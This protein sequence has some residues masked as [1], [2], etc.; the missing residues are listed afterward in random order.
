MGLKPNETNPPVT[1]GDARQS[2]HQVGGSRSIVDQQQLPIV[3]NLRKHRI[4][5]LA[6]PWNWSIEHGRHYADERLRNESASFN[7]HVLQLL[8]TRA[9]M[10]KPLLIFA[11]SNRVPRCPLLLVKLSPNCLHRFFQN[12]IWRE[13]Y[14]ANPAFGGFTQRASLL[15]QGLQ[16]TPV[17]F[18]LEQFF[19]QRR[20]VSVRFRQF[21]VADFKLSL[22]SLQFL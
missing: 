1:R 3:I 13:E 18:Q 14:L 11:L 12:P 16:L 2:A 6:E 5:S 21:A 4:H 7:A 9:M 8:R 10:L 17:L 15:L 20:D 19:F 22:Q